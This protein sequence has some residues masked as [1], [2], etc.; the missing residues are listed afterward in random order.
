MSTDPTDWTAEEEAELRGLSRPEPSRLLEE[1]VVRQLHER[2]V[3]RSRSRSSRLLR[4]GVAA[5]IGLVIAASGFAAGRRSAEPPERVSRAAHEVAPPSDPIIVPADC[6]TPAEP[7]SP[8]TRAPSTHARGEPTPPKPVARQVE[9]D[10][11]VEVSPSTELYR[12]DADDRE[13]MVLYF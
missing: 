8:R 6:P 4:Y 11:P 12:V 7:E 13:Q 1:R 3:L 10:D 5:V 9:T 2:G